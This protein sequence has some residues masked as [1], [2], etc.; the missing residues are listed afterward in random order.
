MRGVT[1]FGDVERVAEG[2]VLSLEADFDDFHGR[3]DS[4]G[5]GY[6]GSETGWEMS[7]LLLRREVGTLTEE[8]RLRTHNPLVIR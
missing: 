1:V 5:F 6:A 3:Y 8:R 7:V 2:V 4:Y